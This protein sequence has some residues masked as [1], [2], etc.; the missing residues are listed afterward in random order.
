MW[1]IA[2]SYEATK[3]AARPAAHLGYL[4]HAPGDVG[5]LLVCWTLLLL[6][7][8]LLRLLLLLLLLLSL[9]LDDQRSISC[10]CLLLLGLALLLGWAEL[11]LH[12]Q[13]FLH[14]G[15]TW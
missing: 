5:K 4:A 9:C 8:L 11:R 13:W 2:Q 6:L 7:L 12:S 14:I 1:D 10:L 15:P 3:P